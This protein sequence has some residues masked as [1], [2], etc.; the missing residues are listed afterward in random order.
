MNIW[1]FLKAIKSSLV[2]L[3]EHMCKLAREVTQFPF[4]AAETDLPPRQNGAR[5]AY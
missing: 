2:I 3:S 1:K 5:S 4:Q